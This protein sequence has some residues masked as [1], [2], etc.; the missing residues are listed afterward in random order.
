MFLHEI[1]LV[2]IIRGCI[3]CIDQI[4][5]FFAKDKRTQVVHSN[6]R[7]RRSDTSKATDSLHKRGTLANR[8]TYKDC[9]IFS[10]IVCCV[11]LLALAV[12]SSLLKTMNLCRHPYRVGH[13]R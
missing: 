13:L 3:R 2:Q 6:R 7:R 5:E 10:I 9:F 11:E 4:L 12:D 1:D 8:S